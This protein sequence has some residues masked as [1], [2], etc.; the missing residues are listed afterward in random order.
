MRPEVLRRDR[1]RALRTIE[2]TPESSSV[3]AVE[4]AFPFEKK[5]KFQNAKFKVFF[6]DLFFS[7]RL[8]RTADDSDASSAGAGGEYCGAPPTALDPTR[9]RFASRNLSLPAA[10]RDYFFDYD[11][12]ASASLVA[13]AG[14]SSVDSCQA[15]PHQYQRCHPFTLHYPKFPSRLALR[16]SEAAIAHGSYQNSSTR[17]SRPSRPRTKSYAPRHEE[18]SSTRDAFLGKVV[19]DARCRRYYGPIQAKE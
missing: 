18:I 4:K 2:S 11:R 10:N 9:L 17:H 6:R 7:F 15:A 19:G 13:A 3:A 5:R 8:L 16:R 12:A 14:G 1:S